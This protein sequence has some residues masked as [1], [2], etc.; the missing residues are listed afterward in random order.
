VVIPVLEFS[1]CEIIQL[2]VIQPIQITPEWPLHATILWNWNLINQLLSTRELQESFC[3]QVLPFID[4]L[5]NVLAK[6]ILR[7]GHL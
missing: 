5:Y 7:F 6:L 3:N 1:K 4:Q 2:L